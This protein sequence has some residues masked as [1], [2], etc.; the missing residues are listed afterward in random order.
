MVN[1][2]VIGSIEFDPTWT[3]PD[4]DLL[5]QNLTWI[6]IWVMWWPSPNPNLPNPY[7]KIHVE[8]GFGSSGW[9]NFDGSTQNPPPL[10]IFLFQKNDDFLLI[11][12]V[13]IFLALNFFDTMK[14]NLWVAIKFLLWKRM[15]LF[16]ILD[17][18]SSV[19]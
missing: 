17:R 12:K 15:I 10:S 18:T 11:Y 19:I 5:H 13:H 1:Y 16:I 8:F 6:R 14:K 2:Q 7:I 4:L 3:Q 9:I